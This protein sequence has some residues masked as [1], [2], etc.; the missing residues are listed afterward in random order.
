RSAVLV[1]EHAMKVV[2]GN[3]GIFFPMI[4]INGQIVGTW[5]RKLKAKHMEI[6]CTPFEPLGA[7]EADVREAA[8][9]YG[10]FMDLPISLITVE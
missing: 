3:N 6:T 1:A 7:L 2:P 8:Q 9:A 4:V 10:D 5:K